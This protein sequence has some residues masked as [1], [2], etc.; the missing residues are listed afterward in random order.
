MFKLKQMDSFSEE[1]LS[2]PGRAGE[3][4]A[5]ALQL[6]GTDCKA[7]KANGACRSSIHGSSTSQAATC[8]KKK[9]LPALLLGTH[10]KVKTSN[11]VLSKI[12]TMATIAYQAPTNC[13]FPCWALYKHYRFNPNSPKVGIVMTPCLSK[14]RKQGWGSLSNALNH[15]A[16]KPDLDLTPSESQC[17]QLILRP[18]PQKLNAGRKQGRRNFSLLPPKQTL[19]TVR[20]N[21]TD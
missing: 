5:G 17:S 11:K 13:Q 9:V 12:I 14:R 10:M 16:G 21:E 15:P 1:K 4:Q 2:S 19:A 8:K 20:E 3:L 18:T 6:L 7:G